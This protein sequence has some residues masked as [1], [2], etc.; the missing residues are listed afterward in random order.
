MSLHGPTA[1]LT[2][3]PHTPTQNTLKY[4]PR[5][6]EGIIDIKILISF[7]IPRIYEFM[8]S[9]RPRLKVRL[10]DLF[11]GNV[12][13]TQNIITSY[14]KIVLRTLEVQSSEKN[15]SN[16]SEI[17]QLSGPLSAPLSGPIFPKK[18]FY[19]P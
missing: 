8:F 10:I 3:W 13:Y 15:W 14:V 7:T 9:V 6:T 5:Q 16:L 18:V 12:L 11:Q 19:D 2:A 1:I 4:D 17:V